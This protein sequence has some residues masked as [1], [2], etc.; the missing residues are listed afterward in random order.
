MLRPGWLQIVG[1]MFNVNR[2]CLGI[3]KD[4][5]ELQSTKAKIHFFMLNWCK[6]SLL[7]HL[8][9]LFEVLFLF[10]V[11]YCKINN[12]SIGWEGEEERSRGLATDPCSV[13]DLQP[14]ALTHWLA[15]GLV[16]EGSCASGARGPGLA[17]G[18]VL[19]TWRGSWLSVGLSP[20]LACSLFGQE[21]FFLISLV[22]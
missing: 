4:G 1:S 3:G 5:G 16:G 19:G 7:S 11:P 17:A 22:T 13:H 15:A 10:L 18:L 12:I 8:L 14:A 20:E 6:S 2:L 21:V 9:P